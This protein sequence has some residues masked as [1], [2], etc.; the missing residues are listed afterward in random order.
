MAINSKHIVIIDTVPAKFDC[1]IQDIFCNVL[2]DGCPFGCHHKQLVS[3]D[4]EII[5]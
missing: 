4:Q 2:M 5:S 1:M 3:A